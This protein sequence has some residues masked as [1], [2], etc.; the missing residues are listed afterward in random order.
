MNV[1]QIIDLNAKLYPDKP[2]VI[3]ENSSI[4]YKELAEL[5]NQFAN[6]LKEMGIKKGSAVAVYMHNSLEFAISFI[7]I[8][9]TGAFV[10][11]INTMLK[12]RETQYILHNSNAELIIVH[13]SYLQIIHNIKKN[14]PALKNIVLC[15]DTMDSAC[16]SFKHL[17]RSSSTAPVTS[18]CEPDDIAVVMY[19]SGTTGNPK[20]VMLTHSNIITGTWAQINTFS[21]NE[22]D[23]C[24]AAIPLFTVSGQ[25]CVFLAPLFCGATMV[26]Q[27]RYHLQSFLEL[28]SHYQC[29]RLMG[30][31]TLVIDIYNADTKSY[32][33]DR[34]KL[35]ITG[36]AALPV[37]VIEGFER[38]FT[39]KILDAYGLTESTAMNC[40][41]T[42]WG[43]K[44]H[45][46]VGHPVADFQI[47]I[48]DD[49]DQ[50]LPPGSDGEIV[51]RGLGVMKGYFNNPDA[52]AEAVRN[53]WLHTGDIG[54]FDED[55]HL[56]IIDRKKDMI[57]V[58]GFNVYPREM[59]EILFTYP[60]V[61]NAAVIGIPD[62][63]RGEIPCACI[64]LR[65]G[66]HAREQ[67][68]MEYVNSRVAAYKAIRQVYF[69]KELPRGPGGKILKREMRRIF[70]EHPNGP[71]KEIM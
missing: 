12:E 14:L 71:V 3:F 28:N 49:Q 27:E 17:M 21:W 40:G 47:K 34:W 42:F 7:G 9:K 11:P 62:S 29:T 15:S 41:N 31:P 67:D 61:K 32:H 13:G 66:S 22:S 33:L 43:K 46:S 51:V 39:T 68:I 2:A 23:V 25:Q 64:E 55:G 53:G 56:F 24:V 8:L 30:P 18:F 63:R 65:E 52:T 6:V 59:E 57:I 48:V 37:K 19:T 36:G 60:A 5:T 45:G 35:L 20:G 16:T 10:I 44:K 50:E 70:Q 4:S 1:S 69:V 26:L 38:K 58:S 54:R